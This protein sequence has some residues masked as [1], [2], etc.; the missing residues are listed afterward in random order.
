MF[1]L[2][3]RQIN[4]EIMTIRKYNNTGLIYQETTEKDHEAFKRQSL[5][6]ATALVIIIFMILITI[7]IY[8]RI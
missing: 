5:I 3:R 1:I 2:W 4:G 7:I 8:K 6:W